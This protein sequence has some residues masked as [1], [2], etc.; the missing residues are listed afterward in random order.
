VLDFKDETPNKQETRCKCAG[1][2]F[3]IYMNI[4]QKKGCKELYEAVE[5]I[6]KTTSCKL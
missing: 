3:N 5:G 6:L 4:Y 1:N 2:L